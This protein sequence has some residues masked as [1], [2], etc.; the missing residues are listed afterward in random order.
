MHFVLKW[1]HTVNW[2]WVLLVRKG[3]MTDIV[4]IASNLL[5]TVVLFIVLLLI[6]FSLLLA[7]MT[8]LKIYSL[9]INLNLSYSILF[10][11]RDRGYCLND[12]STVFDYVFPF[13]PPGTMYNADHQCRLQYGPEAKV[14]DSVSVRRILPFICFWFL[15]KEKRKEDKWTIM[16]SSN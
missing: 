9:L 1:S 10:T 11:S 8:A 7:F 2:N 16:P 13:L 12:E 3:H 5:V 14:C 6:L 15:L 4:S